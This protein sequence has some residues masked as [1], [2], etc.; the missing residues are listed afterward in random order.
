MFIQL[1]PSRRA[2]ATNLPTAAVLGHVVCLEEI[3]YN[4]FQFFWGCPA[5][6]PVGVTLY[7][8]TF[9]LLNKCNPFLLI[10]LYLNDG[11]KIS[12]NFYVNPYTM[13]RL[14]LPFLAAFV[15]RA[16]WKNIFS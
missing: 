12:C 10:N 16:L 14:F 7:E 4:C 5:V 8:A 1:H 15:F 13:T 2:S 6:L 3:I 11:G 9:N